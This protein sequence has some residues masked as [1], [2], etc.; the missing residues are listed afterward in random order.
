MHSQKVLSVNGVAERIACIGW[1]SLVKEWES[2]PC[3]GVWADDGPVIAVEFP[4]ESQDGRMTLVICPGMAK[5]R[6][7]W[8]VLKVPD[9]QAARDCLGVREY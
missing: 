4:R 7:H 8:T 9:L 2:L 5:V 3:N 6:T 1:G